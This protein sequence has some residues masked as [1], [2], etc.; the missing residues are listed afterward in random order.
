MK[1][2][3]VDLA[4]QIVILYSIW[5]IIF[6]FSLGKSDRMAGKAALEEYKDEKTSEERRQE[7]IARFAEN[8]IARPDPRY[9]RAAELREKLE[10]PSRRERL[11]SWGA[12]L[13]G[14]LLFL[15]LKFVFSSL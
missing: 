8:I 15:L 13:I 14:A 1:L 9:F 10:A 2:N 3:P 7:L 4:A 6:H 12:F 5:R 11:E